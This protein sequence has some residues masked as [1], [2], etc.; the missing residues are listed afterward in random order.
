MASFSQN[1]N[2][3]LWSVRFRI[4]ENNKEVNKRLSGF[5][6]KKEANSAYIEFMSTYIAP[7]KI[8]ENY[9]LTFAQLYAKYLDYIK[10]RLKISSIFSIESLV[11]NHIM[12][13]FG[14]IKINKISKTAVLEW[15]EILSKTGYAH[16]YKTKLRGTLSTILKFGMQYYD[17]PINV[18]SL[19]TGFRNTEP[20]KEINIYSIEE[21]KQFISFV[22]DNLYKTFFMF[23]YLTG[24]RKGEAFALNWNDINFETKMLTIDK[25]LNRKIDG[26]VYEISTTPKTTSSNRKILLPTQLIEQLKAYKINLSDCATTD[27]IFGGKHPMSE[28]TVTRKL[29]EYSRLANLKRI[30]PHDFRHSHASLLINMGESI[31]MV[32]KRLGHSDI[33]QT[34]NTYSHLMPNQESAMIDKLNIF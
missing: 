26:A 27:F 19:V 13:T 12:P 33:E 17:L 11:D 29:F 6:Q 4:I 34:L 32:S 8:N 31:V 5:K 7:P 1:K 3:K 14:S 18:V 2:S 25:T 16:N 22:D 10:N 15:Q 21:F 24:C 23:L 9:D 28:T 20:K 30:T